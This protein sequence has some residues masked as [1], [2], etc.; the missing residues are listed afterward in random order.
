MRT[1]L[2]LCDTAVLGSLCYIELG[3]QPD[4]SC[5]KQPKLPLTPFRHEYLRAWLRFC[6][7]LLCKMVSNCFRVYVGK[8]REAAEVRRQPVSALVSFAGLRPHDI[9]SNDSRHCR[10][11][12]PISRRGPT[13]IVK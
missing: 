7:Y 6:L 2:R 8:K 3:E 1:V 4:A 13:T 11:V 9:S 5:G 12:W 10:I